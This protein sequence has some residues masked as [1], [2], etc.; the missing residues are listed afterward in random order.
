MAQRKPYN[1]NTKYGRRKLRDQAQYN[2]DNGTPEYRNDIDN[3]K[4]IVW[5]VVLVVCALIFILIWNIA[6]PEAAL[7]W[8]K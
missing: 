6:G 7:K 3:M 2:Y 5:L 4:N 8:L 1:P